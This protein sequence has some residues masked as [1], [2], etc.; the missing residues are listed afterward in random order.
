MVRETCVQ[1]QVETYQRF[2]KWYLILPNL[3]PRI[4]KYGSK[5]SG[6]NQGKE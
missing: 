1:S 6:A 5:V 3:T 2:K 4:R